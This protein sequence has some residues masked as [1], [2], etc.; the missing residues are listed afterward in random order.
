MVRRAHG[1]HVEDFVGER[2]LSIS[3]LLDGAAAYIE[4]TLEGVA[5]LH[6]V[7][8]SQEGLLDGGHAGACR[9]AQIVRVYGDIAPE[10]HRDALL[11]ATLFKQALSYRNAQFVLRQEKHGHAVIA[12]RR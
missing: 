6:R 5:A 8:A 9:L 12:F 1:A 7:G 3:P 10:K 11:G 4:C 2:V